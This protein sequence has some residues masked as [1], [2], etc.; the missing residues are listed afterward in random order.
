MTTTPRPWLECVDLHPDVLSEEFS[1]DV[2]AL[3]LGAL[4]DY[5][6]GKD[7]GMTASE[8][9]RVPAVYRDADSFFRASYLTGGLKSLLE[10]VLGRLAGSRGS[11]VLKLLTPFGGGK[12]HTLAAL[13]HGARSRATLDALPEAGVFVGDANL[14]IQVSCRADAE[15]LEDEV[16]YA[17]AITLEVAE[18]LDLDIYDEVRTA[19]HA[20]QVRSAADV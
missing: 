5:L 13:L 1:E 4:A 11:R 9:P 8:L 20:V 2:F 7:L 10:D 15:T 17:L 16:P 3:D 12:S 19:V 14:E 18:E 6:L